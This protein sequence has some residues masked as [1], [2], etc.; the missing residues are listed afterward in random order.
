ME[1]PKR[2]YNEAQPRYQMMA[3]LVDEEALPAEDLARILSDHRDFLA[4]GGGGGNWVTFVTPGGLETGVVLGVYRRPEEGGS[5]GT[6]A[7]LQHKR[8]DGLDLRGVQLPYANLCGVRCRQQDLQ[9]AN[10]AGCLATDADF[11]GSSFRGANLAGADL[12][13]SEVVGC[14]FREAD[15]TDADLEN[16]DLTGADMRGARLQGTRF[17]SARTGGVQW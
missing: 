14:D 2:Q 5:E 7:D 16:A 13:R 11:S 15:L 9:G 1:E 17:P 4:S 6:Q 3:L 8:L 10:L 12:S